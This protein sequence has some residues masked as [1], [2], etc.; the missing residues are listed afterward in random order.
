MKTQQ[1]F[2]INCEIWSER[3]LI[4]WL[5]IEENWARKTFSQTDIE[6][7]IEDRDAIYAIVERAFSDSY[8][9]E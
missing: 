1:D 3:M 7:K 6:L 8:N 9:E 4:S 2:T 5:F